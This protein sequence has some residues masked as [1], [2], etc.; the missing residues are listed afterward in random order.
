M[1]AFF[2][3]VNKRVYLYFD[4]SCEAEKER[5]NRGWKKIERRNLDNF[6]D[7]TYNLCI[8]IGKNA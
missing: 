4:C 8:I 7:K 5:K 3:L 2:L 6:I 1:S